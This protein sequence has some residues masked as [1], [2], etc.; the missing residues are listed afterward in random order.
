MRQVICLFSDL[1]LLNGRVTYG[2][3]PIGNGTL[4]AF[5][6]QLVAL[7]RNDF[8]SASDAVYRIDK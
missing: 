6:L 4:V 7:L 2:F 1:H 3:S 8:P 5:Q